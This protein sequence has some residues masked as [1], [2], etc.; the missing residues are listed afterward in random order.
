LEANAYWSN[1]VRRGWKAARTNVRP[2]L[3]IV[4]VALGVLVGY[5]RWPAFHETLEV[6]REWKLRFGFAF[7]AVSTGVFG[8][9]LPVLFRL[10][11]R[12]TRKDPQW[13]FLPFFVGFWALKGIEVDAFYQLQAGIFGD[14]T[15]VRVVVVKVVV[16]QAVYCPVWAVPTTMLAY[17]WKDSGYSV[18]E[19]RRRLGA[20][21]YL[22]RCLPL[23]LAS[24][25][26]WV[27]AVA[28]IY[29]LPL[30]LQLPVQN[31][32]LCLSVLLV[33][34]LTREE[35]SRHRPESRGA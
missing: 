21:W 11:P 8:G 34:I 17:L 18:A 4:M 16:D 5:H 27:P 29:V 20:H 3:V 33:M 35:P 1:S 25:A 24:L 22:E 13:R 6:V 31:L 2:G 30:A 23:L 15:D 9:L 7:S 28:I 19:V 26:I 14:T 12:E 10:I 32:V